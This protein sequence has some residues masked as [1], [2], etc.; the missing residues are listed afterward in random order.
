MTITA[1]IVTRGLKKSFKKLED[2]ESARVIFLVVI[3]A[4]Y[5]KS[6]AGASFGLNILMTN[7]PLPLKLEYR[8]IADLEF[9]ERKLRKSHRHAVTRMRASLRAYG[10]KVPVLI[11]GKKVIDGHLR[12]TAAIQEG[13]VEVP[14]ILCD[15]WSDA[16]VKAFRLMVNRSAS[17]A[18]FDLQLVA[19][20]I[21]DGRLPWR[22]TY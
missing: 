8:R 16:L 1:P 13:Y 7:A 9:Y 11:S 6:V 21:H 19:L 4:S 5:F 3:S 2:F 14:V 18:Q 22:T 10:F 15:D 20:E 12:I 17:W